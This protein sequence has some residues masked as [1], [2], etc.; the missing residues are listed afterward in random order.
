MV[1]IS[2]MESR[3]LR[4]FVVAAETLNISEAA[5]RLRVTQPALSRQIRDLE[6]EVGHPLFVRHPGG[7]RLTP[8]GVIL[9]E[10]GTK[11]LAAFDEALRC[12]RG[13][14]MKKPTVMRVGY[15]GTMGTWA[16]VLAPALEKMGPATTFS[17]AELTSG[18]LVVELR[19]GRLDVAVLGPGEYPKIPGVTLELVCQFPAMVLAPI[20]HRLAKKRQLALEDLRDEEIITLSQESAPGRDNAFIAACRE[21]G[22]TPRITPIGASIPEAITAGIK[23]MGVGIAGN[24]AMNLPYPGVVYIKFK[25]P[26]VMLDLFVAYNA[27]SDAA[28]ALAGLIAVEAR[29]A[30]T[31]VR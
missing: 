21:K 8:A 16:S 10:Q 22:F 25:P 19:E 5:R 3:H 4:T 24:F 26:G 30:V 13:E 12:A 15:Y 6:H 31:S 7:L 9:H 23:R 27:G 2:P 29:R 14:D 11:A 1:C 28:R 20:N 18:Q 17:V